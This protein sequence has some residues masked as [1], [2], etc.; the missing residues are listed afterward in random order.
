MEEFNKVLYDSETMDWNDDQDHHELE[1][2]GRELT[3]TENDT[4]VYALAAVRESRYGW[5]SHN[6]STG[7][8]YKATL[9]GLL[10]GRNIDEVLLK[11]NDKGEIEATLFD[12]DGK[13]TGIIKSLTYEELEELEESSID[14]QIKIINNA[15]SVRY[16]V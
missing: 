4:E 5:I 15:E 10:S 3:D 11:Q 1:M 16:G 12:K 8:R 9:E 13:N 14:E 6:G 2:L 7:V